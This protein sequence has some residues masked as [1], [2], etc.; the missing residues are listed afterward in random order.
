M[1]VH[2]GRCRRPSGPP[3]AR[4]HF[5]IVGGRS[6]HQAGPDPGEAAR[7]SVPPGHA[8]AGGLASIPPPS[9]PLLGLVRTAAGSRRNSWVGRPSPARAVCPA[10][11]APTPRAGRD[12]SPSNSNAGSAIACIA[13]AVASASQS[14]LR[15]QGR[16]TRS[17]PF[18]A[19]FRVAPHRGRRAT[20]PAVSIAAAA[21]TGASQAS[22]VWT[23]RVFG[24]APAPSGQ[25]AG[26][27]RRHQHQLG[28]LGQLD[29]QGAGGRLAPT[30][31]GVE[32]A[33][34]AA[35]AG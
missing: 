29:V 20:S 2:L 15:L 11:R 35:E 14:C 28:P 16:A 25:A 7:G 4:R 10:S 24:Q 3:A 32:K 33:G 23:S 8:Q 18:E 31:P 17:K 27:E 21:S 12:S 26:T 5:S 6:A 34:V 22:K 19:A 9:G 13:L 1:G 30:G